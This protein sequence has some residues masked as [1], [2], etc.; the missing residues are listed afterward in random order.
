MRFKFP[1]E[2]AFSPFAL[3][4]EENSLRPPEWEAKITYF[5]L[6]SAHFE[7][8]LGFWCRVEQRKTFLIRCLSLA[9]VGSLKVDVIIKI[10]LFSTFAVLQIENIKNSANVQW[11][12]E[13]KLKIIKIKWKEKQKRIYFHRW[14][15]LCWSDSY[16][17]ANSTHNLWSRIRWLLQPSTPPNSSF[18]ATEFIKQQEDVQ[19]GVREAIA[20]ALQP[21]RSS[22]VRRA[23]IIVAFR[24]LHSMQVRR[25]S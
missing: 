2:S 21:D 12:E 4:C 17:G 1:L 13:K 11:E 15:I 22:F 14:F 24:P 3:V 10:G 16:F 8:F 9:N 19:P 5:V 18:L 20:Q 7:F 23:W 6:L 25:R